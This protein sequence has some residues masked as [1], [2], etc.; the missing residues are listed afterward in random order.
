MNR[1]KFFFW[2]IFSLLMLLYASFCLYKL[3]E[4]GINDWD[5]A[6]H[7]VSTYE[8]IRNNEWVVTTYGNDIDYWNLKP[9]LSEWIM[10]LGYFIFGFTPFGM[11]IYS[12][13][14]AI[15]TALFC[16]IFAYRNSGRLSAVIVLL[17]FLGASPLLFAHG[18]RAGDADSLY[19]FFH[20]LAVLALCNYYQ[21]EDAGL[22]LSCLCFS[23][24]FLTKSWHAGNVGFLVLTCLVWSKRI[25]RFSVKNWLMCILLAFGPIAV[26][27]AVRATKDGALFF[28]GMLQRDLLERSSSVLE[29]H[30]GGSDFLYTLFVAL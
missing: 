30:A 15:L 14:A 17:C 21:K 2:L 1:K 6:R 20:T 25:F 7:G 12:A 11:R 28:K 8:M 18:A 27:A 23:L 24:A 5:E 29:G 26:W 9:P 19:I 13:I 16:G 4:G 10:S 3:E 22:Y